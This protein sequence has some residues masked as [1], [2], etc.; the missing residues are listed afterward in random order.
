MFR[1]MRRSVMPD[2]RGAKK[3]PR[4]RMSGKYIFA[5]FGIR[6][7]AELASRHPEHTTLLSWLLKQERQ[8]VVKDQAFAVFR[9]KA[10]PA[11]AADQFTSDKPYRM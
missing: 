5:A 9:P 4:P 7:P 1:F 8:S 11:S 10:I 2:F 6:H 3:I